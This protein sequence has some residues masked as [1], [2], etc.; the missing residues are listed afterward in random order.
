MNKIKNDTV[1]TVETKT[2]IKTDTT[3]IDVDLIHH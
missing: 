1:N 2:Y 3:Y